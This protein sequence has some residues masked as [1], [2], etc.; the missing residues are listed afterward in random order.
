MDLFIYVDDLQ[1]T[2]LQLLYLLIM[3]IYSFL[4]TVRNTFVFNYHLFVLGV[5]FGVMLCQL[6][7][8]FTRRGLDLECFYFLYRIRLVLTFDYGVYIPDKLLLEH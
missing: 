3:L 2:V 5:K 1:H 8:G 6:S 4:G 7:E